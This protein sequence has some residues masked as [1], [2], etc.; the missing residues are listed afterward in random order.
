LSSANQN[1]VLG[2]YDQVRAA[3]YGAQI[4]PAKAGEKRVYLLQIRGLPSK[5]EAQ[6]LADQLKGKYGVGDPKISS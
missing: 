2:V 1:D 3:G 4:F 5:V 6:A